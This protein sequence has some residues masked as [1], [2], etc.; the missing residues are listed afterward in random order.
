VTDHGSAGLAAH[1]VLRV[2]GT[3]HLSDV[4]APGLMALKLND[5]KH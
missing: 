2:N 1:I 3:I 4:P 5:T